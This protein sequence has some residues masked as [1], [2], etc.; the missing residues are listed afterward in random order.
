MQKR[1]S[2]IPLE[3]P[4]RGLRLVGELDMS[5][6]H[7]LSDALTTMSGDSDLTLELSELEFIDSSGLRAI[8][9]Y[10]GSLNGR[11]NLILA[12]P[13]TMTKRVFE[14]VR[15]AEHPKIVVEASNGE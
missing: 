9:R 12:N 13:S 4:V 1:L 15:F 8:V 7:D 2:F 5:S 10:A 11:G 6:A 14:I 3:A